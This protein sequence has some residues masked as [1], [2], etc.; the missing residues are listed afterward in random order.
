MQNIMEKVEVRNRNAGW[1]GYEIPDKGIVRNFAPNEVKNVPLEELKQLQY[2]S[3]G[4]YLLKHCLLI[5]D[6]D[7]LEVLNMRNLEPEYFYTEDIIKK[8]LEEGTLDQ[9]EDCLNFAPDGVVD[10]IKTMAVKIELPD[11][12]K[13]KLITEKTGLNID[14]AIMVNSIMTQDDA[15][16]AEGPAVQRKATPITMSEA[17]PAAPVRKSEPVQYKPTI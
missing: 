17:A 2:V 11:T 7:A 14:N 16:D 5:N 4:D 13:R 12:R 9:L 1:T 6:E 15:K 8:L 3:G 10:L